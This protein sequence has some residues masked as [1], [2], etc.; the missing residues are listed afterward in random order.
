MA[1]LFNLPASVP[2]VTLHGKYLG[3]DGRPLAGSVEFLAPTPLTFPEAEA[4][5]TGPVVIPLDAEGGFTVTLPATDTTGSNPTDW[6]YWV[7]ERL[8]GMAD[9]KPYAVK[10]PQSLVDPWLDELA[11]TDPYTPTY[12]AVVGPPGPKGEIGP[13]GTKGDQGIQGVKGDTGPQGPAGQNGAGSGTVTAVN[14]V[15]PDG[16][17]NVTLTPAIIGAVAT[18]SVGIASGI[19]SLGTNGKVPA[20]QLP[21]LA[22]PNAVTS[23]NGKAGPTVTLAAADVGAIATTARA[24]ANG[25]ASLDAAGLIPAAQIAENIALKSA[26]TSRASTATLAADNHLVVPVVANAT[27]AVEAVVVWT[28]G[29]G[30]MAIGWTGPSGATMVWTDN[31]GAGMQTIGTTDTFS[32]T[33][34]TSLKGALKT[35]TTAGSLTLRW[36]QGTSNAAATVLK[37]GCYLSARRIA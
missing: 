2:T 30:G 24:T 1:T 37:S 34:G 22:D 20:A 13:Q 7:A 21:T 10:I 16:A 27:Y 5:V 12:V 25:V 19:A 14:A 35:G 26:D 29:G 15:Q 28:N 6:A 31:D 32:V 11:P 3:P 23:V 4:F 8:Q 36:A 9:R 18:A 17:G 33:T